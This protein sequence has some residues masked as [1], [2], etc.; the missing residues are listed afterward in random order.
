[1][2][3]VTEQELKSIQQAGGK[4]DR[5]RQMPKKSKAAVPAPAPE[6]APPS[7]PSQKSEIEP[8]PATTLTPD[9]TVATLVE[10]QAQLM[11]HNSAMME[12]FQVRL[13]E[14]AQSRN[15]VPWKMHVIRSKKGFIDDID[16]IPQL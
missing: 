2:R 9:P 3:E 6:P 16:L 7:L 11:A 5:K 13:T 1:M 12:S 8:P 4:V 10:A 14:I 15:P